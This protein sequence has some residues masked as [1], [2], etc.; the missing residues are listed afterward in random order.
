MFR[1]A[2]YHLAKWT[3][4]PTT[5]RRRPHA[6]KGTKRVRPS[7]ESLETRVVPCTINWSG[8][9][10]GKSWQDASNWDLNRV[11]GAADDVCISAPKV[12]DA[13]LHSQGTDAI[14]SLNSDGPLVI[15]GGSLSLA[16]FSSQNNTLRLTG[17]TLTGAGDL[18]LDTMV[19]TGGT[20]D[21]T[22][23]TTAFSGIQIS[24]GAV[25]LGRTLIN[26]LITTLAGP[27]SSLN[28]TAAGNFTNDVG[29]EFDFF[30]DGSVT[31]AGRFINTGFGF[32]NKFAGTGTS[33]IQTQFT[34]S[35]AIDVG[36][37]TLRISTSGVGGGYDGLFR[38]EP[39]AT[40]D[41]AG[42]TQTFT[43]FAQIFAGNVI[44]SGGTVTFAGTYDVS[45]S[46]T[47]SGATVTFTP[48]AT[49]NSVG[50]TLT[51]S[52]ATVNCS[53]PQPITTQYLYLTG[54]TLTGSEDITD[55]ALFQWSGGTL[56]GSGISDVNGAV[57]IDG[58]GV[59]LGRTLNNN[60]VGTITGPFASLTLAP[61]AVLNNQP[62]ADFEL[63]SSGG[64]SGSGT[65]NN[66]P[67]AGFV[68]DF[69]T[70]TVNVQAV[71]NN[72][73]EVDIVS[74]TLS[75]GGGGN[76]P[77]S[78]I[79]LPGTT[80]AFSGGAHQLQM[81]STITVPNVVFSGGTVS[82]DGAYTASGSSTFSGATVV[83]NPAA[84]LSD[85]GPIVTVSAA[86]V[87]L[88][89]QPATLLIAHLN[90][91]GGAI[92]GSESLNIGFL[93]W[94]GGTLGA[95]GA[96]T[97]NGPVDI[98]GSA[99]LGRSLTTADNAVA[100]VLGPFSSLSLQTGVTLTVTGDLV[101]AGS[102]GITGSGTININ[103]SFVLF[104]SSSVQGTFNNAGS[105][106]VNDG[107]LRLSGGGNESGSF[108]TGLAGGLDFAS[109]TYDFQSAASIVIPT[110]SFSGGTVNLNGT[111]DAALASRFTGATVTFNPG[112]TV[113]EVGSLT[114]TAGLVTFTSGQPI[115]AIGL[116]LSGGRLTGSDNVTIAAI[117]EW[118]GGTMDGTGMT[119]VNS[120]IVIDGSGMTLGRTLTNTSVADW[121][122]TGDINATA[123]GIFH[124]AVNATFLAL[125]D[126]SFTSPSC[127]GT[128]NN[129][130]TFLKDES[131]G[132]TT[133][134]LFFNN[135]G[136]EFA[137]TG[138]INFPCGIGQPGQNRGPTAN[139]GLPDPAV[140][141]G[142]LQ[143]P[144]ADLVDRVVLPQS[145]APEE[146]WH[147]APVAWSWGEAFGLIGAGTDQP[148][149][150]STTTVALATSW[151][152]ATPEVPL[153][154]HEAPRDGRW[155]LR[156]NAY[157][158]L[159]EALPTLAWNQIGGPC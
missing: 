142:L 113:M 62:G 73:G 116:F 63:R 46:S 147:T 112:M 137:E 104:G 13:V 96:A 35:G 48:D 81:S 52:A 7:L 31:G 97:V 124:N 132:T 130:G 34:N 55:G 9:G 70:G 88:N 148:T 103:N 71:F 24:G 101:I 120:G 143:V 39:G 64:M 127:L 158:F 157:D 36:T 4:R 154:S 149:P 128:F 3:G 139:V 90:L 92:L 41:F 69:D 65:F 150:D 18:Y 144:A 10:D 87:T 42:G 21:G 11:P 72:R 58:G 140:G 66:Q 27:S 102:P 118:Q 159:E 32:I 155:S 110:V 93:T 122:G 111:Y 33:T 85:L 45:Q 126:Q 60:F 47:F 61:G 2:L 152:T 44:F 51:V 80:L 68:R 56:S 54:G 134:G 135:N 19:W 5:Y 79:G 37:G 8:N 121:T 95:G 84:T 6:L 22:G 138:T 100:E 117:L 82:V 16:A 107:T 119:T 53:S 146:A 78:F 50:N 129:D 43:N 115:N 75:L 20:M 94:N 86:G 12:S 153:T 106:T 131:Y 49:V 38:A 89:A 109:G 151:P 67:G 29:A 133:I 25:T 108:T 76:D 40:I 125:N 57:L 145:L 141:I 1:N 15:S 136:S 156:I 98:N 28:M 99:T 77:G 23:T 30:N 123:S 74:G 105:V 83:F 114:V 17:G 91:L 14:Q 26:N 59:T